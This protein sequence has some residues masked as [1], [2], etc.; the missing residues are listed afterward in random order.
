[1]ELAATGVLVLATVVAGCASPAGMGSSVGADSS[2]GPASPRAD[3]QTLS[4]GGAGHVSYPASWV[5]VGEYYAGR[6]SPL[7]RIS[8]APLGPCATSTCQEFTVPSNVVAVEF[9]WNLAPPGS[10]PYS[11]PNN[12]TIGGQPAYREDWGP[13]NAHDADEG[14]TW[15]LHLA[16]GTLV[17][18]ASLEGP[19]LA[20]GRAALQQILASVVAP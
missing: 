18:A 13:V 10:P 5:E 14:H 6:A 2:S 12:D 8:S 4:L 7:G 9:D 3:T 16:T 17:I 11:G 19:D 1:M 15:I 20:S